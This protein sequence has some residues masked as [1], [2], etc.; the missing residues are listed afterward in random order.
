MPSNELTKSKNWIPP[1]VAE[2]ENTRNSLKLSWTSLRALKKRED[3][4]VKSL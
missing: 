2:V 3:K 1:I 4:G